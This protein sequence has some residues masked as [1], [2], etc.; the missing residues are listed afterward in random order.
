MIKHNCIACVLHVIRPA[1][2]DGIYLGIELPM[3]IDERNVSSRTMDFDEYVVSSEKRMC[4]S[5]PRATGV[6]GIEKARA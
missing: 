5:S 4:C 6:D 3:A 1:L 2:V